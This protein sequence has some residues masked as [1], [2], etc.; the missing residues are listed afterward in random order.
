V[1][2]EACVKTDSY[3]LDRT[4]G[5]PYLTSLNFSTCNPEAS[6]SVHNTSEKY[7][8]VTCIEKGLYDN[9]R[10]M[11]DLERIMLSGPPTRIQ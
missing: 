6:V 3:V 2:D 11:L 5:S 8:V 7:L 9:R 4:I 10:E 1:G